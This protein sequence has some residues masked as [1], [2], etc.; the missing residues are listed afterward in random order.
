MAFGL[1]RIAGLTLAPTIVATLMIAPV[2]AQT[3]EEALSLAYQTN[4]ALLAARAQL[5]QTD[6]NAPLARAGWRPTVSASLSAG[7]TDVNSETNG[8]TGTD[9]SS[10][11]RTGTLSVTQPLYTGGRTGAAVT[12]A[13]S[14]IQAQRAALFSTEQDTLLQG[15]TA[16][17]NVIRDE[18]LHDLQINNVR[19]LEKQLEATRDRFRVGEVTRTDVAQA[20]S[21]LA[22]SRADRTQAEGNLTTSR[23][24]FER[25][26][27]IVPGQVVKPDLAS[28]LPVNRD[29]A[30]DIALGGNFTLAQAKFQEES[31]QNV[32][33]LV[34][35]ELLPSLDLVAQA[36]RSYD[37]GGGD[38]VA[39][40]LTAELQLTIP[41]YQAGAVSSRV[42]AAKEAA[43]RA[44]LVV[45]DQR[46][47]A[48]Q[49][50]AST[51]EAYQTTLAQIVSLRA[52]VDA[53]NIALEGVEQEATVGARTVLDVLDAEQELL[54]A[55]VSLVLAE[56]DAVI[57]SYQLLSAMG[58]LTAQDLGL[59]VELYDYDRHY[60]EV[61]KK[62]YGTESPGPLP[63]N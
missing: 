58:R 3:L 4:P 50:A 46:R 57:A 36:A 1:R 19:R 42:R 13:D 30:V 6:E 15:V 52:E 2:H 37:T 56:R 10:F 61:Y 55:Q 43:N 47:V 21:R 63:G 17:V 33:D 29:E 25:V 59:S 20:E 22:R 5:R 44:R 38:N 12:R 41:L 35:G 51:F 45:D 60:L 7:L 53:S 49:S 14:D 62:Y 27:G 26:I 9:S 8:V 24:V 28:N 39:T 31:S 11:P 23:V 32:V 54:D 48:V 18:S 16:Y 34:F 40:D